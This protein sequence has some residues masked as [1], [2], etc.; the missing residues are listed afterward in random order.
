[1][2][3][4]PAPKA[5]AF[6]LII[7]LASVGLSGPDIKVNQDITA[8]VQNEPSIV[9]NHHYMGDPLN[10][11]VGYNDIGNTLGISYSPDSGKTWFDVQL[12]QKW[13]VS[14]DPS[15]AA[16]LNGHVYACFLSYSSNVT[17]YDTSGI[18]VCKSIDGGRTWS[19]PVTVDSQ[20]YIGTPV[21]FADKCMMTADTNSSSPYANNIYVGWQRDDTNGHNSDVFFAYSNNGGAGFS[22]PVQLNNNPPQ[23]AYAEGA[24]PFVGADGD[25]YMAWYDCYF[26][27]HEPGSL[28]VAQSTN[29]G[30]SFGLPVKAADILAPP[31]YTFSNTGF[32]AKSFISAAADPHTPDLIYMTYISDP[33]GYFDKR[34]DIGKHPGVPGSSG[35]DWPAIE[36]NGNYVYAAWED[37]RFGNQDI[38]FNVSSDN[39][40]TW[41]L[42]DIGPLDNTDSPGGNTSRLVK[43]ASSGNYVYAVWEDYRIAGNSHIFF[44]RSANNGL[45]WQND[46]VV[47]GTPSGNCTNPQI[48]AIAN[49]VYVVW[50]DTRNGAD[51]IYFARSSDYGASW[52]LP[53]RVDNGDTPGLN[54]STLP[55]LACTGNNVYCLWQDTR[56]GGTNMP[57]FNY[58]SNNGGLWQASSQTI[59]TATG[60][61]CQLPAD[62]AL[63]CRGNYVY[64]CWMDDRF[65]SGQ[66]TVFF[67]SSFNNGANWSGELQI[68]D[69]GPYCASPTMIASGND[70][71]I[72]WHDDR[73]TGTM[74]SSEVFFDY[75]N[76]NGQT[77]QMPDIGPLDPGAIGI[78]SAGVQLE[79]ENSNVYAAWLDYR[80]GGPGLFF[81]CSR[82]QGNTW[83]SDMQI[84]HGTFPAA[85]GMSPF[86]F[87]SGNGHVNLV[88]SDPRI[89][90]IPNIYTNFS[91]DSGTT[92]LSGLDEADVYLIQ[93]SDGGANWQNP[94]KVNDDATTYAQVLPWVLVNALGDVFVSYYNF[95]FTPVN[96]MFP[97]ACLRMAPSFNQGLS[98][99]PSVALQDTVVTPMTQWVG[100]YNGMFALDSFIYTVFTDL[101]QSGN[102]DIYL[103]ISVGA[104]PPYIC[105]DANADGGVNVSDAVWIINYVFASG[106]PPL[107]MAAGEVNCDGGVNVSDAVWIINFVFAGGFPSCDTN[108]DG[109]PDC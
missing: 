18:Y 105:G 82:N 32:K 109:V 80:A 10:V 102:S 30:V 77:W 104:S 97:G 74:I 68:N 99:Q 38:Y 43:L 46:I 83:G 33:D 58:S 35:S 65:V 6:I 67:N 4:I 51:D 49:H 59:S 50:Q 84:N 81:N 39:G 21:K 60:S 56:L 88:W 47:D 28:Y 14:G 3:R 20:L 103:D 57:Y 40:K 86:A 13:N 45:S 27:G 5:L 95:R 75:S 70:V 69:P 25:V 26:R 89:H 44:N 91:S 79:T 55:Q 87:G 22:A 2:Q 62:G 101:E 76:D 17:F 73:M 72:A 64:A 34:L 8:T 108:G 93:S 90:G 19:N 61:W 107:P 92:W 9:I 31:L 78:P 94:V 71:Y 12:P 42:P 48:C 52:N 16:D 66:Y 98:F 24:F 1:M 63:E 41:H 53:V 100:E 15:V 37:Y 7:A 96:P 29:G 23:T 85:L 11:V 36:R 106:Q 54:S